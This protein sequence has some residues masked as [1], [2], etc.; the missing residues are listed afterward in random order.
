MSMIKPRLLFI[1]LLIFYLLIIVKLF[2]L[3]VLNPASTHT[4]YLKTNRIPP[5]RGKIYDRNSQPLA[6]NRPSFLLYI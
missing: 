4:T 1:I 3:Q 2:Q 5:E 6:V